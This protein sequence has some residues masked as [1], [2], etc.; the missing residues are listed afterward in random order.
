VSNE[1]VLCDWVYDPYEAPRFVYRSGGSLP[2]RW[3]DTGPTEVRV[4][5]SI[6]ETIKFVALMAHWARDHPQQ[7]QG[8]LDGP[9]EVDT[10]PRAPRL[11]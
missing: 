4:S 1:C 7:L 6:T 10:F 3:T 2:L 8:A 5:D 11:P 9:F